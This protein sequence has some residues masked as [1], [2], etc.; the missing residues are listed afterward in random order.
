MDIDDAAFVPTHPQNVE[1][2]RLGDEIA[3]LAA[4]LDAA[5]ARLLDLI[6]E[7]DARGGWGNGF[8]SCAHWLAWRVGLALG[9]AREHVRVARALGSLPGFREALARGEL[10]YEGASA[11]SRC[12]AGDRT[13]TDRGRPSR[14][15]RARGDDRAGLAPNGS[16]S[17]SRRD[18]AAPPASRS[19]RVSRCRRH[20]GDSRPAGAGGRRCRDAGACCCSRRAVSASG[21]RRSRGN[22]YARRSCG[23][24][25]H[26]RL[27]GGA[28]HGTAAGGRAGARRRNRLAPRYGSRRSWAAIPGRRSRR[29][30]GA[31]QCRCAGPVGARRGRARSRWNVPAPGMRCEPSGDATRR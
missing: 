24:V 3:T 30:H 13:A 22:A 5:T 20:G 12:D 7:F 4:H 2:E 25:G 9:A 15:R 16:Q 14:H 29:C 10:S 28:D 6:R 21:G 18:H 17:R 8:A 31:G 19:A 1:L 26:R 23:N 27:V 11:D